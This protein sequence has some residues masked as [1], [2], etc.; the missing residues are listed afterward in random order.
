M[1]LEIHDNDVSVTVEHSVFIG[2]KFRV[3]AADH[4]RPMVISNALIESLSVWQQIKNWW[5]SRR[6]T[7]AMR[8][9]L[10]EFR[11]RPSPTKEEGR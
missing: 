7:R 5:H 1:S 8:E 6:T 10:A 11:A 2:G 4:G 3:T 9:E